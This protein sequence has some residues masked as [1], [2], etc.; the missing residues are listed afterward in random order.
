MLLCMLMVCMMER[1]SS[2]SST[3][4]STEASHTAAETAHAAAEA[5]HA[6]EAATT[7]AATEDVQFIDDVEHTVRIDGVVA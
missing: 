6:A 1:L 2:T 7:A 3:E 4:A 5:A